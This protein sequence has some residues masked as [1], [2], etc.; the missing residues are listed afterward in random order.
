MQ[1]VF[2]KSAICWSKKL[3]QRTNLT[4]IQMSIVYNDK[5]K[6]FKVAHNLVN[7][8]NGNICITMLHLSLDK[9]DKSYA[10]TRSFPR[11]KAKFSNKSFW[12]VTFDLISSSSKT[13][14][15]FLYLRFVII[16]VPDKSNADDRFRSEVCIFL[17]LFTFHQSL[18]QIVSGWSSTRHLIRASICSWN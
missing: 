11:R 8:P 10:Q 18:F 17:Y 5:D 1:P 13:F 14:N 12:Q 3:E 2:T 16:S 7:P 4:S 15:E 6:Q 9:W